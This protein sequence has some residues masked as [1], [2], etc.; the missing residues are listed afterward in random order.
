MC[1]GDIGYSDVITI[2]PNFVTVGF[3]LNE[4]TTTGVYINSNNYD[5]SA[6]SIQ[7]AINTIGSNGGGIIYLQ[8]GTYISLSG[9]N[10]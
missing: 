2:G 4:N 7:A 10:Y 6:D 5:Y 3:N 8:E 1:Y 9:V